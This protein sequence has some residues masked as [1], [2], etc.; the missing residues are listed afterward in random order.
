RVQLLQSVISALNIYWATAF[1]LPKSVIRAI[2]ARMRNFLWR[3]GADSGMAKVAWKDV[4]KP[5]EEGGKD[6]WH[7][8]GPLIYRFPRGPSILRIPLNVKLST[9]IRDGQWN[10]PEIRDIEHVEIFNRLPLLGDD[11]H[12]GWDSPTGCRTNLTAY[13]LF[14][15]QG[16]KVPW[17]SLFMG[18]SVSLKLFCAMACCFGTIINIGQSLVEWIE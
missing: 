17:F 18:L 3:G 15:P 7:P 9:I 11:D 12:I 10:W 6:S 1:V 5:C 14:Q 8:L 2:E 16:P 13:R 4:C